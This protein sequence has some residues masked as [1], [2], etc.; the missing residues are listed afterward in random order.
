MSRLSLSLSRGYARGARLRSRVRLQNSRSGNSLFDPKFRMRVSFLGKIPQWKVCRSWRRCVASAASASRAGAQQPASK[1]LS[2]GEALAT[3]SASS[4]T[5]GSRQHL[6]AVERE[7][8]LRCLR[9]VWA[10]KSLSASNQLASEF[11][12]TRNQMPH[13]FSLWWQKCPQG[14]RFPRAF[15]GTH[16]AKARVLELVEFFP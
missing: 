14:P 6:R 2:K 7:R 10:H 16:N 13:E 4:L 11:E 15:C 1:L 8:C 5:Q 12:R 9:C 3:G